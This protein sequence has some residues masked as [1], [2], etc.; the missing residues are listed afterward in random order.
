M[1]ANTSQN[2]G[3]RRRDLA[4]I[5]IAKKWSG[6]SDQDYREWLDKCF[7][8]TSAADLSA[9]NRKMVIEAFKLKGWRPVH[10]SARA[11]GMHLKPSADREPQLSK[12]GA[13]LA[14]LKYPWS[15]ADAIAKQMYGV[16]FVRFL[17]PHQLH[18]VIAAL[19]N[20]HKKVTSQQE[21]QNNG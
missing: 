1:R 16:D 2:E 9:K 3:Q 12:I 8:V 14:D 10:K 17:R 6:L 20:R 5:H 7:G 21:Q 11:S 4:M 18:G 15:Y 13:I 19:V